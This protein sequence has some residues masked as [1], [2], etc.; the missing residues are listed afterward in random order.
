MRQ[1][2]TMTIEH[3]TV[4]QDCPVFIIAEAGVNHNGCIQRALDMISVAR[5]SGANAIKFQ[6]FKSEKVISADAPKADYQKRTTDSGESQL[7]MV[8]KLELS[9]SDHEKLVEECRRQ[10]ITF[11]STPF[12]EDSA[13]LLEQ[14]G[15]AAYKI[16]SG[17]V[18]NL[19]LIRHIAQK[20]LPLVVSTGM[21]SLGE[22]EAAVDTIESAGTSPYVLLH[23]VSN[24][25][26]DPADVNLRAMLALQG[27]FQ[28][29]VGY[30]D[31][32]PGN[33][34]AVA[35]VAMGA[36]VIEK[37]FTL[38]RSLPGPDHAASLEPDELN[39][40]VKQIRTAELALGTGRKRAAASEANT[41]S[42]A[43]KSLVAAVDIPQGTRLDESHLTARRP[44]TGIPPAMGPHFVDRT[45]RESIP[46]G[47][48]LS[49]EMIQ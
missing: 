13:D 3:N 2:T 35:A 31:H 11:M 10:N 41:A 39:L 14:L 9:P 34:V 43:R 17:E 38:D 46:A 28:V 23:C 27:A 19:P 30:S 25:P 26:A 33:A 32:T 37:H 15:I 22:V 42:V 20:N 7:E 21:C 40:L 16:P 18:T 45:A 4:G 8:K 24:Y 44:G 48:V 36:C 49:L 47:T 5:E 29:P 1:K 12:E 6:T